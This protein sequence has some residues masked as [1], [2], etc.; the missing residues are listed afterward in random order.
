MAKS[1]EISEPHDTSS[2][3]FLEDSQG[4]IHPKGREQRGTQGEQ[5]GF[6]RKDIH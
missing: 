3:A 6:G 5:V 2:A 4:Y 1:G